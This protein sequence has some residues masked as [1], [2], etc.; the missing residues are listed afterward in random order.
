MEKKAPTLIES[1]LSLTAMLCF[2]THPRRSTNPTALQDKQN[3]SR[4]FYCGACP[5]GFEGDGVDC[6]D[7]DEC[8][9]V[10]G[11]CSPVT[12]CT[13]TPGSFNCSACPAGFR[14]DGRT[15]RAV[16]TCAVQNGGCDRL[17]RCTDTPEGSVCGPCPSGFD[18]RPGGS[19]VLQP[20]CL[21]VR[22]RR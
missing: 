17:Q 10:P 9:A 18:T 22:T 2:P 6:R 20:G 1:L 5:A 4:R 16:S 19:C 12:T 3:P 7:I 15:C 8:S 14:G 13:N 21:L 11:A